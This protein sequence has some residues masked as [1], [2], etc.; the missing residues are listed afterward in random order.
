MPETGR[1]EPHIQQVNENTWIVIGNVELDDLE[2]ILNV[3]MELENAETLTGLLFHELGKVPKD[4]EQ[5][6][7]FELKGFQI[8]ITRIENHQVSLAKITRPAASDTEPNL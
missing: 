6:I 3:D 2:H 4:G 1:T 7:E 5:L 8:Q